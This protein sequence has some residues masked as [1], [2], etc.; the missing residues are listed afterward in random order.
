MSFPPVPWN[1][2]IFVVTNTTW[3]SLVT[4]NSVQP[5]LVFFYRP[6]TNSGAMVS[7]INSIASGGT[8]AVGRMDLSVAANASFASTQ[9]GITQD[10]TE[11]ISRGANQCS[12]TGAA[13]VTQL[14]NLIANC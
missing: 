4:N 12:V 1:S 14:K 9:F 11:R 6:D 2:N 3:D 5:V 8:C 7:V 10:P 13:T